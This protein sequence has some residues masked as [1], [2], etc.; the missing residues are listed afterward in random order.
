MFQFLVVVVDF[1]ENGDQQVE[2]HDQ[3]EE[4]GQE[5]EEGT[6]E[7]GVVVVEEASV[8]GIVKLTQSQQK[9]VL[10]T[11]TK[12]LKRTLVDAQEFLGLL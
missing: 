3:V 4:G 1:A 12:R 11:V 6:N 5:E 8:V 2:H 9:R 10:K 7:A